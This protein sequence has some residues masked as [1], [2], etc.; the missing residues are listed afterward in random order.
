MDDVTSP[1]AAARAA[2]NGGTGNTVDS[3]LMT[4]LREEIAQRKVRV[5][6]LQTE[7]DALKPELRRYERVLAQLSDDPAEQVPRPGPKGPR[8]PRGSGTGKVAEAAAGKGIGEA[9]LASIREQV[10]VYAEDHEEFRQADIRVFMGEAS[11]GIMTLAFERLR[12]DGLIRLARQEGNNK[13]F[14]LT[15]Q[16]AREA[17]RA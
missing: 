15:R 14:R 13:Y 12:Q 11:S 17:E 9:R 2:T 7:L 3:Q 5:D 4:L 16:A 6:E 10:L 1:A 8:G